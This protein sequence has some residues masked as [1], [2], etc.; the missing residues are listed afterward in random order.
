[1]GE[2]AEP[3]KQPTQKGDKSPV[4]EAKK[5]PEKYGSDKLSEDDDLTKHGHD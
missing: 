5:N 4:D 2:R 3:Q 1:M